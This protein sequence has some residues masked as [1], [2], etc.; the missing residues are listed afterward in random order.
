MPPARTQKRNT[1]THAS[2]S[3]SK[4]DNEKRPTHKRKQASGDANAQAVPGVQKVKA[5]L[6]QTKR[7][8]AKVCVCAMRAAL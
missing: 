6:R 4:L 1:Q 2:S 8:L 3:K 7:L 5:A